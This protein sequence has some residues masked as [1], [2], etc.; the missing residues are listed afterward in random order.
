M[1][2]ITEHVPFP[3]CPAPFNMAAHVLSHADGLGDKAALRLVGPDPSEEWSYSALRDIVLRTAGGLRDLGLSPG[4]RVL[5]RLGNSVDFP[6]C[7]LAAIAADLVPIPT[8]AALTVPEVDAITTEIRPSLIVQATDVT[9]PSAAP[10]P[11][12]SLT[13]FAALRRSS[14]IEPVM[15]DPDRLAYIIYTSGSSGR[16][17]PVAHAHRAVWA[18]RM[19]HD[20]WLGLT[21]HDRLMHVGAFNW[22]YTLGVGLMDPW[23]VGASAIIPQAGMPVGDLLAHAAREE[24]T[25]IAAAP[26]VYRQMLKQDTIPDL[27]RLRHVVSAGEKLSPRIAQAWSDRTGTP[28]FEAL[29]M[30]ECSTFISGSPSRP[31]ASDSAGFAQPGRRIA[32]LGPDG[33]P[34]PRGSAGVLAIHETDPGLFLGYA[35]A[36]DETAAKFAGDWFVTGD[37]VSMAQD[38]AITYLGRNDDMMNAGGYRVSPLEVE[39]AFASLDGLHAAAAVELTVKADTSVIALFYEADTPL[40]D[41]LLTAHAHR[42]LARY[43]QPRLFHHVSVLPKGGNG[44]LN[45]KALRRDWEA[46]HD[47]A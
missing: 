8:S 4:A 30:S 26:G 41:G 34:V 31:A 19:M 6:V 13:D 46:A 12:L 23:A 27:P 38:G 3:P 16:P 29:G 25:I 14:P 39:T 36:P 35:D 17:R 47:P 9:A 33:T 7:Y 37:M 40:D 1:L 11:V 43:K 42:T 20:G 5:M 45:R 32:V 22:T 15:G 28:V 2:S 44:K 10:C 21:P 24:V 18:R